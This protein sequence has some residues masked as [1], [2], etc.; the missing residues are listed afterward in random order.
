MG[1]KNI[2]IRDKINDKIHNAFCRGLTIKVRNMGHESCAAISASLAK[3]NCPGRTAKH[4]P[5]IGQMK[6]RRS[7]LTTIHDK[8][9]RHCRD[10]CILQREYES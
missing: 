4:I 5:I 7:L 8:K 10:Y 3:L 2:S 6:R 1:C 9:N